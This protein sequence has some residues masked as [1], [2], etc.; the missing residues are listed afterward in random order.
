MNSLPVA[1]STGQ[2]DQFV[3]VVCPSQTH[4]YKATSIVLITAAYSRAKS[5]ARGCCASE[6]LRANSARISS[7]S[8]VPPQRRN[9]GSLRVAGRPPGCQS[10]FC[11]SRS[12]LAKF[13]CVQVV[14]G[15]KIIEQRQRSSHC[16]RP[17]ARCHRSLTAS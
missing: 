7:T 8:S 12:G 10:S 16:P 15:T 14:G 6:V 9:P 13:A 4:S 11:G 1:T 3:G 2:A 5:V 17:L